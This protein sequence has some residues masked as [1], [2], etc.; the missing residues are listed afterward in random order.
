MIRLLASGIDVVWESKLSLRTSEGSVFTDSDTSGLFTQNNFFCKM[1]VIWVFIFLLILEPKTV[2]S[3]RRQ[4]FRSIMSS[5]MGSISFV[6]AGH[7]FM[8][9]RLSWLYF[10]FSYPEQNPLFAPLFPSVPT[11]E[12]FPSTVDLILNMLSGSTRFLQ[13]QTQYFIKI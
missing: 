8:I 6:F 13:L 2:A 7:W 4:T 10:E 3:S 9:G 11:H 12:S 5:Y 1:F